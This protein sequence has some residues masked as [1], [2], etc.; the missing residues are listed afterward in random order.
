MKH[1]RLGELSITL[2]RPRGYHNVYRVQNKYTNAILRV[3]LPL[4]P[5]YNALSIVASL[6]WARQANSLPVPQVLRGD[7]SA[8][9][10]LEFEWILLQ[11]IDGAPLDE[12][13]D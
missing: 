9:N 10:T 8:S 12:D 11:Y 3:L 1:L 4:E 5:G 6:E 2:S 13:E 7:N